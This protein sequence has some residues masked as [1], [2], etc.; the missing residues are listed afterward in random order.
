MFNTIFDTFQMHSII[1]GLLLRPL[2]YYDGRSKFP[3]N[4]HHAIKNTCDRPCKEITIKSNELSSLSG[5]YDETRSLETSR[6]QKH[7]RLIRPIDTHCTLASGQIFQKFDVSNGKLSDRHSQSLPNMSEHSREIYYKPYITTANSLTKDNKNEENTLCLGDGIQRHNF[8]KNA[9]LRNKNIRK[10][11]VSLRDIESEFHKVPH[12]ILQP[13]VDE[14]KLAKIKEQQS[15]THIHTHSKHDVTCLP[16][17][18]HQISEVSKDDATHFLGLFNNKMLET[19]NEHQPDRKIT[20]QHIFRKT[21]RT[22]LH[23]TIKIFDPSLLKNYMAVMYLISYTMFNSSVFVYMYLPSYAIKV[24]IDQSDASFLLTAVGITSCLSCIAYGQFADLHLLRP[25]KIMAGVFLLMS[26]VCHCSRFF[27][28]FGAL[29]FMACCLGCFG[30]AYL[31]LNSPLIVDLLGVDSLGR[32]FAL[33]TLAASLAIC[34]QF[35]I[36]GMYLW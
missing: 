23:L 6:N 4:E 35:P 15:N 22:C 28:S 7:E 2:S 33:G 36:H 26:V 32:I 25:G 12:S 27:T 34:I 24:S 5:L 20:N 8:S 18:D 17:S 11:Y 30:F 14:L 21:R 16:F 19:G 10:H 31:S 13:S 9:T 3:H 29:V 1:A